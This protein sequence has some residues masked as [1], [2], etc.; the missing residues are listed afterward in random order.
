MSNFKKICTTKL[1]GKIPV[2]KY[3]STRTGLTVILG[4][5][6]GPVVNGFFTLGNKIKKLN[7]IQTLFC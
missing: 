3:K 7:I 1:N 2:T 4:E 6:E 5:V